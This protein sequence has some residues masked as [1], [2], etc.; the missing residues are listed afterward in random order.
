MKT[1]F[2]VL[3]TT[4]LGPGCLRSVSTPHRQPDLPIPDVWSNREVIPN[5]VKQDWWTQFVDPEL[6]VLIKETHWNN[7]QLEAAAK[8]LEAALVEA[9]LAGADLLPTVGASLNS[10]RRRQNFIGFPIPGAEDQ[11]PRATFTNLGVSL[12]IGWE[13]DLWGRVRSGELRAKALASAQTADLAAARQSLA[14][15]TAKAWFAAS[16]ALLQREL[17]R[18]T[19]ESY[20]TSSQWIR[21]RFEAGLRPALDLRLTLSDQSSAESLILQRQEQFDRSIRQ[22]ELL[23]GRYPSGSLAG[24]SSL[25][26]LPGRI[27]AGLPS[28][29]LTRRPDLIAAQQRL[30]AADASIL[31]SQRALYPSLSLTTSSGTSTKSL[32]DLLDGDFTV[33]SL[34]GNLFQPLF[35][36]GRL[37]RHV[38]LAESRSEEALETYA[39][40]VLQAFAEVESALAAE[41]SLK[42][43]L[44]KLEESAQQARAASALAQER[45]RLGLGDILVIL[46]TDRRVL[47]NETQIL[48]I[49]RLLLDNRID[50]YLALGGGFNP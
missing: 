45:Y 8:R 48:T 39:A 28:Q 37:Q 41:G 47:A 7:R 17:T 10:N 19:V 25:P 32:L 15:Q 31:Q 1:L 44:K 2:L 14:A 36:G 33:W 34:L 9:R 43:R 5:P 49:K 11:I 30:L 21:N 4:L 3:A 38:E 27:P 42:S 13:A 46:E 20:R 35:Q 16:E 18:E 23:T 29:L 24:R 26:D 40:A 6:H 22:V 50:L 12:D